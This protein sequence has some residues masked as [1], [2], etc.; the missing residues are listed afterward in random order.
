LPKQI[1]KV[2]RTTFNSALQMALI[3]TFAILAWLFGAADPCLGTDIASHWTTESPVEVA[4]AVA[5]DQG[6]NVVVV[7]NPYGIRTCHY[8]P[9]AAVHRRRA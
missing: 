6:E 3:A 8:W 7:E 1:R 9:N 4:P 2:N 5:Q